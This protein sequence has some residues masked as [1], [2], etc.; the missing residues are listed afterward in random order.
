M[1]AG[2]DPSGSGV[3][4]H[5]ALAPIS[6]DTPIDDPYGDRGSA[7]AWELASLPGEQERG[8]GMR[9]RSIFRIVWG[10]L[11]SVTI[12]VMTTILAAPAG[13]LANPVRVYVYNRTHEK[14]FLGSTET[15]DAKHYLSPGDSWSNVGQSNTTDKTI[16]VVGFIKQSRYK[17]CG[18]LKF[19]N[20]SLGYPYVELFKR[21]EDPGK[22]I[23]DTF[24]FSV[25]ES[26]TFNYNGAKLLVKRLSDQEQKQVDHVFVTHYKAWDLSVESCPD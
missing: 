20:P 4:I 24:R 14:V 23:A 10:L 15:L 2:T 3:F 7:S 12:V 6:L 9:R 16:N 11:T 13:A 5:R 8:P 21:A 19:V 18:E 26:H 25:D 17:A 22:G 1:A